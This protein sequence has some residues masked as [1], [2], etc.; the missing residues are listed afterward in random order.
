VDEAFRLDPFC[1]EAFS[2]KGY[3]LLATDRYGEAE[4]SFMKAVGIEPNNMMYQAQYEV[5][6]TAITEDAILARGDELKA[7]QNYDRMLTLYEDAVAYV[8]NTAAFHTQRCFALFMLSRSEEALAAIDEAIRIDPRYAVAH[9]FQGEMLARLNRYE[10]AKPSFM[11][12]IE[13]EPD[14]EL[15]QAQYEWI[16][17]QIEE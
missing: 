10:E 3:I 4:R 5:I 9:S 13:L 15:Y 14:N 7:A 8:A 17:A 12:A 1:A 11:K 16:M 2:V 6:R